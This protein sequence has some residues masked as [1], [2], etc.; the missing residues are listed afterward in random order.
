MDYL[1]LEIPGEFFNIKIEEEEPDISGNGTVHDDDF[2]RYDGFDNI[3]AVLNNVNALNDKDDGGIQKKYI[4]Q[5]N[6]H[7]YGC[8]VRL[9]I[10][11]YLILILINFNFILFYLILFYFILF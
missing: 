9:F 4:N 6:P 10:Y 5:C 8:E 11:Y 7:V 1:N 3:D 2:N